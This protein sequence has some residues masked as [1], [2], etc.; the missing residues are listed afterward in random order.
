M[1]DLE[2]A[3]TNNDELTYYLSE[4]SIDDFRKHINE[5]KTK[6]ADK[7]AIKAAIE[8]LHKLL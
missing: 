1:N 2:Q 8:E 4:V 7:G 3:L 5:I 6:Y